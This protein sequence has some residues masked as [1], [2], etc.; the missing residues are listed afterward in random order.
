M[1]PLASRHAAIFPG[2]GAQHTGMG[3]ELFDRF[4][5]Y[6]RTLDEASDVLRMD[7]PKLCFSAEHRKDLNRQE[8]S[9]LG[10][11]VTSVAMYRVMTAE[12]GLEFSFH[13]GH[14][15]GEYSALCA[16]GA[17]SFADGL[18]LVRQR[19]AVIRNAAS[20]LDGTMMWVLNLRPEVVE[21]ACARA[22]RAGRRVSVSAYDAPLQLAISGPQG[23]LLAVAE[24]LEARGALVYPLGMEG[25]YHSELMRAAADEMTALLKPF[26]IAAPSVPVLSTVTAEPHP[27]GDGSRELLAEQLVA[28]VRWLD[29]QRRLVA[30]GVGGALEVGPGNVLRFLLEKTTKNVTGW[31][32]AQYPGTTALRDAMS[33]GPADHAD[34]VRGCLRVAA[35]TP[36]RR[37]DPDRL[38]LIA[39]AQRELVALD[40]RAREGAGLAAADVE[41]ALTWV[42]RILEAKGLTGVDGQGRINRVLG[43]R[44]WRAA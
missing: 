36:T 29:V 15:L 9:Q 12:L 44:A 26:D 14:S 17:L 4:Q 30:E 1:L 34:V 10:T 27:G 28:P 19:G 43:G 11:F 33:V 7:F 16:A 40:A 13:A 5:I 41:A 6:R 35:S 2:V 37:Q 8:E 18:E 20:K 21:S 24:E 23:D 22:A 32:V 39:R 31:S 3:K 38:E 25:P 42:H